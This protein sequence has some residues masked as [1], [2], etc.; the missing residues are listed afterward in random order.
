MVGD[1]MMSTFPL[2]FGWVFGF[3]SRY[4][5]IIPGGIFWNLLRGG[6]VFTFSMYVI[7]ESS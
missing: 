6:L 3:L 4:V 5:Y 7:S 2:V 1:E